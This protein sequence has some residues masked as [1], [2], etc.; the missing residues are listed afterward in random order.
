MPGSPARKPAGLSVFFPA[1]N[2]AATRIMK[3]SGIAIDDLYTLVNP[4]LPELQ[5]P[6]NVHYTLPGYNVLGHQVAESILR[7]QS[8]DRK[9]AVLPGASLDSH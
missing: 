1:Y 6:A 8:R 9:G 5:L 2:D 3:E 4:R 7:Q